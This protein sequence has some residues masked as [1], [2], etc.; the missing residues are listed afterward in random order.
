[1]PQLEPQNAQD[2]PIGHLHKMSTTAGLGSGDY[3]AVNPTSIFAIVLAVLSAA[4]LLDEPVL[5]VLPLAGFIAAVVSLRQISRSN[6]TQT[7]SGLAITALLLSLAFGGFVLIRLATEG[8]RT[9]SDRAAIGLIIQQLGENVKA[10]NFTGAYALFSPKFAARV[11]QATFSDKIKFMRDGPVYGKLKG[12]DWAALAEFHTDESTG[13]RTAAAMI[14][15]HFD[16]AD[17]VPT[18]AIFRKVGDKWTFEDIPWIFPT[19]K[20]QQP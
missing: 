3:V 7:G 20:P 1:M 11:D 17:D 12:A 19:P 2:D 16:K 5:L 8:A 10:G 6:G 14:D 9:R 15:L 13:L 18:E 4:T